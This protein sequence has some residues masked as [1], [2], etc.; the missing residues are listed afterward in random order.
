MSDSLWPHGWQHVRLPRLTPSNAAWSNSCLL[1]RRYHPTMSSYCL[2][3]PLPSVFPSIRVFANGSALC[4]KWSKYWSFSFSIFPSNEHPGL[5]SFRKWPAVC[6]GWLILSLSLSLSLSLPIPQFKL[7]SQVSSL[8]L[9]S[10][11]SGLVLTLSNAARSSP[12]RRHLLVAMR[13]SGV[14]FCWELLLGM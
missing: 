8:R 2:P 14:L 11:H 9:L 1:S 12:F 3:H 10:G 5:I 6:S 7:L 4:I 13:A